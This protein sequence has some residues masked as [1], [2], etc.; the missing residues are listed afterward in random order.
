MA[1]AMRKM[2]IY[3]GLVEDDD[4]RGYGRYDARQAEHP[5]DDRPYRGR[6]AVEGYEGR[7]DAEHSGNYAGDDLEVDDDPLARDPEP[8]AVRRE[9]AARPI[10]LA[11]AGPSRAS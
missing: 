5:D 10:G 9:R 3:L 2:G 4:A 6:Y 7:Y 8:L 11:P 1:G